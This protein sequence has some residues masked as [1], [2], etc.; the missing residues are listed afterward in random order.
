MKKISED[1]FAEEAEF[2]PA[3][4]QVKLDQDFEEI[5]EEC[6]KESTDKPGD[7]SAEPEKGVVYFRDLVAKENERLTKVCDDW[8]KKLEDN[9]SCISDDIQGEIRS[10]IGQGRLVMAERFGQFSGLVDNCEFRRGEKE[11]TCTDLMGFWEMIYFQ[12]EDVDKKFMK[13]SEIESNNWTEILKPTVTKKKIAKKPVAGAGSKKVA[14]SGLKALIAAKRKAAEEAKA[15]SALVLETNDEEVAPKIIEVKVAPEIVEEQS[16][17]EENPVSRRLTVKEMIAKKRAQL[18]KEKAEKEATA[19]EPTVTIPTIKEPASTNEVTFE[20]GFFSVVSPARQS[21]SPSAS[22]PKQASPSPSM[23]SR[24]SVGDTLRKSVLKDSTKRMSGLVSPFVS[25]IA[26]RSLQGNLDA[27]PTELFKDIE[28]DEHEA[29]DQRK[30]ATGPLIELY[31]P[32]APLSSPV[33][34]TY[35]KSGTSPASKQRQID[36]FDQMVTGTSP[37][38]DFLHQTTPAVNFTENVELISF[39]SPAETAVLGAINEDKKGTQTPPASSSKIPVKTP[40]RRSMRVA[41]T[42]K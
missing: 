3:A 1:D 42:P 12:V 23:R 6:S 18:A 2:V 10:V 31:D 27:Q 17:P 21:R 15:A 20:G 41:K 35:S 34:K 25:Q 7:E 5:A 24:R 36:A 16:K 13:L 39:D 28:N 14:S 4:K 32:I 33:T 19:T 11:T 29:E 26:R 40:S 38:L 37:K 9:I 30:V 22:S 8:E